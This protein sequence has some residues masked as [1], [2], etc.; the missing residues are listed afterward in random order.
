M[1]TLATMRDRIANETTWYDLLDQITD[2][3]QSAIKTYQSQP[4]TFNRGH[5]RIDTVSGTETYTLPTNL[6]TAAGGSITSGE[7]LLTIDSVINRTSGA[8]NRLAGT[9]YLWLDNFYSTTVANGTPRFYAREGA[10]IRL[11]PIP[12]GVFNI[13]LTGVKKLAPLSAGSDTNA[14]M[15]D[16]EVLIRSRA[17]AI[18]ALDVLG[19]QDLY[20]R[21]QIMEQAALADLKAAMD[22]HRQSPL[23][24]VNV[25]TRQDGSPTIKP[26]PMAAMVNPRG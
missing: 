8:A 4:F 20:Q 19:N 12:N 18:I 13:Y 5:F 1:T 6:K 16:G 14:W 9:S 10:S 17:K 15:T 23:A 7:D 24:P 22:N 21:A 11:G 2:A 26:T 25:Q 3:I